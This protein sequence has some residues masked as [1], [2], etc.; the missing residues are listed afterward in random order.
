MLTQRGRGKLLRVYKIKHV[1]AM[2]GSDNSDDS[3]ADDSAPHV[4]KKKHDG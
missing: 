2:N 3:F 4:Y 1:T